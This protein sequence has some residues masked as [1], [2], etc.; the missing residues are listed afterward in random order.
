MTFNAYLCHCEER[1]DEAISTARME[2]RFIAR[3]DTGRSFY[4]AHTD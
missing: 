2:D 1:R 3:D 4:P